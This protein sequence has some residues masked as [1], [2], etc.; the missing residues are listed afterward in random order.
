MLNFSGNL[1]LILV[2]LF[3]F[4]FQHHDCYHG[5]LGLGGSKR[6]WNLNRRFQT[7]LHS[8]TSSTSQYSSSRL[9]A[10]IDPS[11]SSSNEVKK[12]SG[13]KPTVVEEFFTTAI[14]QRLLDNTE[15]EKNNTRL[16][17]RMLRVNEDGYTDREEGNVL[18]PELQQAGKHI[19]ISYMYWHM[20]I[21]I[22]IYIY[23]Y[24]CAYTYMGVYMCTHIYIHILIQV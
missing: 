22:Y 4:C 2:L 5:D 17:E 9:Y 12:K 16:K 15:E 8:K 18:F 19:Y 6:V 7:N 13:G 21:H 1:L 14:E 10:E 23:I 24:T 20:Y 11:K 3:S